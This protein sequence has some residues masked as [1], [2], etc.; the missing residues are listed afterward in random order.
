M[1]LPSEIADDVRQRY[2]AVGDNF[3][4]DQEL[5]DLMF[6]G[7]MELAT[8]TEC[9]EAIDSSTST[10]SGTI[11]YSLPT[12]AFKIHRVTWN[13]IRLDPIDFMEDDYFT[14]NSFATTQTGDPRYYAQWSTSVYLRPVPNAAQT[15]VFYTCN[16]PADVTAASTLSLPVQYQ[17]YLKDYLLSRM[18]SKDGNHVMAKY[19]QD[20][21]EAN[22]VKVKRVE[23]KRK[24]SD[25][26]KIVKN[27]ENMPVHDVDLF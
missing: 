26:Y 9:I 10:V 25:Q 5:Y 14:G 7:S 2:N 4:A 21:W 1:A 13:G 27:L 18:F 23:M 22:V 3:F 15:L 24:V 6:D 20:I 19:Y 16:Y 11:S 8:E 12:R 17:T